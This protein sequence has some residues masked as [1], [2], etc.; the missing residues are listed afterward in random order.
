MDERFIDK[1]CPKCGGNQ[2]TVSGMYNI[3]GHY[4]VQRHCENC[5]WTD[6]TN[7]DTGKSRE[8]ILP[9]PIYNMR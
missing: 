2:K 5:H 9:E 7:E 4:L 8:G 6:V 1:K 3:W